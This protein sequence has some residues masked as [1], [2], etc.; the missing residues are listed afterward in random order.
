MTDEETGT[1]GI[2]AKIE[3]TGI[4]TGITGEIAMTVVT[5]MTAAGRIVISKP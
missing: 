5:A 1:T 3:G 2:T 4:A